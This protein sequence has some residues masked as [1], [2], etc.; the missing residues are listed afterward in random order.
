MIDYARKEQL[1]TKKG[2]DRFSIYYDMTGFEEIGKCFW[3]GSDVKHKR[4]CGEEHRNL[5][6][7]TFMW[8]YASGACL[9]TQKVCQDCGSNQNLEIHHID[10]INGGYRRVSKKN[11]P[12]NL[13]CLCR[14]CHDERHSML[15]AEL[16]EAKIAKAKEEHELK[17]GKQLYFTFQ[18]GF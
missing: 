6:H 5:Y 2:K 9:S 18:G 17:Y 4:Y 13:L 15:W 16:R 11:R 7:K 8:S 12:E 14:A 3:C 1:E 10:P